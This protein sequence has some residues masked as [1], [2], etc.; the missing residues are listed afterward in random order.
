[1]ATRIKATSHHTNG[2]ASNSHS[3][4]LPSNESNST[5]LSRTPPPTAIDSTLLKDVEAASGLLAA[6]LIALQVNAL[7]RDAQYR[8][9]IAAKITSGNG[10]SAFSSV[11]PYV[12][13]VKEV[14]ARLSV[15]TTTIY[16]LISRGE[17]AAV[18]VG[19]SLRIRIEALQAY[20]EA[21][22]SYFRIHPQAKRAD[23]PLAST[24]RT[25]AAPLLP[26]APAHIEQDAV[27][28]ATTSVSNV[29]PDMETK[30][31][32]LINMLRPDSRWV[33]RTLAEITLAGE[34]PRGKA[35]RTLYAAQHGVD[36]P[37]PGALGSWL[38]AIKYAAKQLRM[39]QLFS[40][41]SLIAEGQSQYTM[42]EDVAQ[43]VLLAFTPEAGA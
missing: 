32:T 9:E 11:D 7:R 2:L 12:Y 27:T 28:T 18:R 33:L 15:S 26:V 24:L 13:T 20:I 36:V 43:A 3:T 21:L 1:M 34:Q 39:K 23:A 4:S 30:M 16:G 42:K 5:Y 40:A 41:V 8:A 29:P 38:R 37:H 25:A 17:L 31:R 35:M 22:P 19:S 6:S 14:A 10:E